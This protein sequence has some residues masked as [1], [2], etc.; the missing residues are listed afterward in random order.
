[1]GCP[2]NRYER[3]KSLFSG[4]RQETVTLKQ[5]IFQRSRATRSMYIQY[6]EQKNYNSLQGLNP[7]L[8]R[9]SACTKIAQRTKGVALTAIT[10]P[11]LKVVN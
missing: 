11:H 6:A 10:R 4:K 1:M 9:L 8:V 5:T 2:A 3:S 7:V